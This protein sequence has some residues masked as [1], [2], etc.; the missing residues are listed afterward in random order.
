[1]ETALDK[2]FIEQFLEAIMSQ[3]PTGFLCNFTLL[4]N[5]YLYFNWIVWEVILN[6]FFLIF[7]DFFMVYFQCLKFLFFFENN[8]D[9]LLLTN[10]CSI[11]VSCHVNIQLLHP[12]LTQ[13]LSYERLFGVLEKWF[14]RQLLGKS[15]FFTQ[16]TLNLPQNHCGDNQEGLLFSWLHNYARLAFVRF[17]HSVCYIWGV[18]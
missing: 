17:D 2:G 13:G 14:Y 11:V 7:I 9:V 5:F 3:E 10:Y 12:V 6:N 1:M 15:F 18:N 16:Q 4:A 8:S